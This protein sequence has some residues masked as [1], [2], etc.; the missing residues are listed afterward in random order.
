MTKSSLV[1]AKQTLGSII[2]NCIC[3]SENCLTTSSPFLHFNT[4]NL[5]FFQ[6][7]WVFKME[8]YRKRSIW[9][10]LWC[11]FCDISF[12]FNN[13]WGPWRLRFCCGSCQVGY[14]VLYKLRASSLKH[15]DSCFHRLKTL[16][17]EKNVVRQLYSSFIF[18]LL[19]NTF[20]FFRCSE[21]FP[22]C[23]MS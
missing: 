20:C 1:E 19:T 6:M 9:I 11:H 8:R 4:L 7:H 21:P 15:K 12:L 5:F 23:A 10:S 18:S 3:G 14:L 22:Y 16:F 17:F 2:S 13:F